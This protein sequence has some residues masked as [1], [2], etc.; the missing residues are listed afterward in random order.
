MSRPP[1]GERAV[2]WVV[3]VLA[4]VAGSVALTSAPTQAAV[5]KLPVADASLDPSQHLTEYETR[6]LINVN[7]HRVNAGLKPVRYFET[8]P[9]RLAE[10]WARHLVNVADF[11]DWT[12]R[13]QDAVRHRCDYSWAGE[14]LIRGTD[15]SPRAAVRA[16]MASPSHRAVLMKPRANRAGIGVRLDSQGRVV[17]VLNFGDAR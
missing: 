2:A 1:A 14:T 7:K 4:L 12:H 5:W 15:L 8:C 3:G 17:G 10:R 13:D 9:D 11:G 16:W 6:I